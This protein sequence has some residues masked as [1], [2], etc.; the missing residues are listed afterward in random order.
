L[1]TAVAVVYL[2][3]RED[4]AM[5]I[6]KLL[7]LTGLLVALLPVACRRKDV[8]RFGPGTTAGGS[9]PPATVAPAGASGAQRSP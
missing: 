6:V 4:E 1:T 8:G 5:R 9:R 2:A 3:G 7:V